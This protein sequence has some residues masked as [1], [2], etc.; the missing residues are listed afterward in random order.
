[1][2]I[3]LKENSEALGTPSPGHY[4][5]KEDFTKSRVVGSAIGKA[6]RA[7]SLRPQ[8]ATVG[9]GY[10]ELNNKIDGPRYG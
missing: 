10:Y 1:M 8:S 2:G 5:P 3:K 4:N 6:G 7:E 9:P